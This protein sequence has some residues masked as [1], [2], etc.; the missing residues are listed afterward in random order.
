M[1]LLET[2]LDIEHMRWIKGR[3]DFDGC[4]TIPTTGWGGGLALLWRVG[5]NVWVDSFLKYHIDSI[6]NGG[7]ESA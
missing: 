1:F 2:W 3:I 4:F 6:I 5:V 7:S